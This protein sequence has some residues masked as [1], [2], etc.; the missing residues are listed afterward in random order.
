M[1]K[2]MRSNTWEFK[3]SFP[4]HFDDMF[5]L[6]PYTLLK[7]PENVQSEHLPYSI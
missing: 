2:Y 1:A 3:P 6:P 4:D 7:S 5:N